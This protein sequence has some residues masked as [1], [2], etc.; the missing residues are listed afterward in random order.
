MFGID[1]IN[2]YFIFRSG[3]LNLSPLCLF[4]PGLLD[5]Q[6]YPHPPT[7]W[8]PRLLDTT[9]YRFKGLDKVIA[10]MKKRIVD[11]KVRCVTCVT[12][13]MIIYYI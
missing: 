1:S 13:V 9:E 5:F 3:F 11:E 4:G 8:T 7:I 6:G 12:Y 2:L 10:W